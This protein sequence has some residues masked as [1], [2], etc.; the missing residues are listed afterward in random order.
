MSQA[1]TATY[2]RSANHEGNKNN[3][4]NEHL[5]I[6]IAEHFCYD[7]TDLKMHHVGYTPIPLCVIYTISVFF[8]QKERQYNM[9]LNV[10]T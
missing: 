10:F 4:V 9:P 5:K 2:F 7:H 8:P 1:S 3:G 6:D